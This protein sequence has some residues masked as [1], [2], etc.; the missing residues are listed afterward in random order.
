MN[1]WL[2]MIFIGILMTTMTACGAGGGEKLAGTEKPVKEGQTVVTLSMQQASAFY[3]TAEKKFEEKYPDIDLQIQ[4]TEDY[5][6]YQKTTNAALLSGKGPDIFEISSL[7]IDDYVSKKLLLNMDEPME[8]DKTLNKSDLQMN[9]LDALKLNGGTYAMPSGFSLRAFVGDGD[10]LKNTKVDDKNWTWKEFEETSKE[11][12]QKES[13][14]ER[15]YAL[16]NDPPE[17][18]LQ[19]MIVDKYA[20]FVD[21]AAKKAKFDSPS[22][23][24]KMQQI[25]KMYDDKVMTSQPADIGK[26]LFYSTVL[27]SPADLINGPHLF[28]SNPKLLQKPEQKGGTRIIPGSQFAIHANSPV[29]EQAWKFIAFLLSDEG[30][31]LQEREGF[32]LLKSVNEK[33]LNAIQEQVKSGTYKLPDGKVPKV[34]DEE[35]TQFKQLV[36]TADNYTDVSGSVISIIGD[37][38]RAF[39][40]EQ[41]SAEEVAK[42]I[43]NKV[44]TLL[45]E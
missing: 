24:E 1:K 44:T 29:K 11:L 17:M 3:Q 14:T 31:S 45:N 4:I 13:G 2:W 23:V 10:I 18:L 37:E 6:K 20:E 28:F 42:L 21:H 32:S 12:M 40:S 22:F 8:Q 26:Q 35:F 38:P 25:K 27:Q 34:L 39:F 30:Q 7:P 9:I 36:N 43:Q 33:Q 5:E 19:E 15:R 41:K 16:A